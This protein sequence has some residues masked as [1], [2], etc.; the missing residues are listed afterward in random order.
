MAEHDYITL[1]LLP[2]SIGAHPAQAG[3]FTM[4][5]LPDEP[6]PNFVYIEHDHGALYQERPADLERYR[7]VF[8]QLTRMALSPEDTVSALASLVAEL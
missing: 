1:R 2:F 6:N 8:S 3:S 4:M 5:R 7:E